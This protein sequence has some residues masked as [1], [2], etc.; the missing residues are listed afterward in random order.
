MAQAQ[1]PS[2]WHKTA[3]L[4]VVQ[5]ECINPMIIAGNI[6]ILAVAVVHVMKAK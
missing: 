3:T 1:K 2:E 6:A 5:A 4:A